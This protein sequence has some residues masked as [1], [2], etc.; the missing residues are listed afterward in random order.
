MG[1]QHLLADG[2]HVSRIPVSICRTPVADV[3]PCV[4]PNDHMCGMTMCLEATGAHTFLRHKNLTSFPRKC[5][6]PR[7]CEIRN[8]RLLHGVGDKSPPQCSPDGGFMP[9]QCK[10]VNT[11]DRMIFD[12]VHSYS[13]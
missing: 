9:V 1:E 7:S 3:S 13:R 5:V 12:L 6:G 11:T 4:V 10:F 8:R 2:Q